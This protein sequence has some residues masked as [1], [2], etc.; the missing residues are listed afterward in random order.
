MTGFPTS[1]LQAE[2]SRVGIDAL[3]EKPFALEVLWTAIQHTLDA[4]SPG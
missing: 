4:S 2:A 1:D 3:L